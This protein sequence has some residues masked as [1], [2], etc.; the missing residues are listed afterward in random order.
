MKVDCCFCELY[1]Y[2]NFLSTAKVHEEIFKPKILF[3]NA[4]EMWQGLGEIEEIQIKRD[5]KYW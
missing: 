1:H 4:S 2:I 5:I 3:L